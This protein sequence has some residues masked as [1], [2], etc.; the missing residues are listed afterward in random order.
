M[1]EARA[2]KIKVLAMMHYGINEHYTGQKSLEP[3]ISKAKDNA[4]AL[5]NAGI[6]LIF[7][8]HYHAND[9]ADFTNE[10]KTLTDIQTGSL[11]TPLSPYRIMTLDDNFINIDTRRVTEIDMELPGGEDFVAYCDELITSRLTGFFM[12]YGN[13]LQNKYQ[14]PAEQYPIAVPFFT[15]AFKAYFAG[16]E[17]IGP[18]ERNNLEA[19]EQSVPSSLA[20]L[21][22]W[23][24]DLPPND[25]KIHIKLK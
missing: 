16:D 6:R 7:T 25:N 1:V 5:M 21:N 2:N 17:K 8:G 4:I 11:V 15:E 9:I 20:L 12:Y 23:W 14:I 10:G 24:T 19:L 13:I 22:S 18:A 3:L